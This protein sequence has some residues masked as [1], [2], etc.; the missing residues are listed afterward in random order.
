LDDIDLPDGTKQA[1]ITAWGQ[2]FYLDELPFPGIIYL[3]MGRTIVVFRKTNS[4]ATNDLEGWEPD[5]V[6]VSDRFR[7]STIES[8]KRLYFDRIRPR[9]E[10]LRSND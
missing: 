7:D 5:V 9:I 10:H 2:D 1:L 8:R 3:T 6:N 4:D